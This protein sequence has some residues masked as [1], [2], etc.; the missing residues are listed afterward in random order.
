MT[1]AHL[2]SCPSCT[3]HVRVDESACPFCG[4]AFGATLH[5]IPRSRTPDLRLGR[6]ALYALSA[7]TMTLA[8]AC[9]SSSPSTAVFYGV[10]PDAAF[11]EPPSDAGADVVLGNGASDAGDA[12]DAD[13]A[14][15]GSDQ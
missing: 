3:R 14:S 10:P 12:G 5:A 7:G 9:S 11:G 4:T 2:V 1:H 8:A 6:A 15:D 13:D